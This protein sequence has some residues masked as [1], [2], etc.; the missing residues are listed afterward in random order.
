MTGNA[1]KWYIELPGGS[2]T[3]F[4][5]LANIFL[6]HFQLPIRYDAGTELLGTFRQDKATHISDHIQ[7]WRRRKRLIKAKIPP[8]YRLEWFLKS[9]QPEI[10]KD[11]SMSGVY[12]EEQAIFRAQQLELIYSQSGI[13]QKYLPDAPGSK[14]DIAKSK[15]GPHADGIV[16]SVDT[17]TMNLLNHLQQLSLQTASNNQ[18][19]SYDSP[20]SQNSSINVVQSDNPK[21]NQSSNGKKKRRSKKKNPDG[22]PDANKSDNNVGGGRNESRKK[23]KFHCKVCSGDHLTHLYPNI[24]GAQRLLGQQGTSSSQAVLTNPFPQVL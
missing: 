17:T 18:V 19:T 12:S 13:L 23:V 1:A 10:S 8:E 11:V 5:N 2:F 15:P 22:K 24:E 3:S 7:E 21:G 9:L 4:A 6:N 16:G 14:V 20:A